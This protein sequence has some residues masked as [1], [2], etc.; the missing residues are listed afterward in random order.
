MT[1]SYVTATIPYVNAR[2]HIGHALEIVQVDVIASHKRK[3]GYD[4]RFV[5]G[6][7]DNA[8]KNVQAARK[9][10]RPV[11]EFVAGNADKFEALNAQLGVESTDFFRTSTDPRHIPGVDRLWRAALANDDLYT[12][13][14][15]GLYCIGCEEFV[16]NAERC[17]DHG[18]EPEVVAETNWFSDSRV[19]NINCWS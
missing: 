14:Y 12:R 11:G 3:R 2:P 13:E 19:M 6:S 8:L 17:P 18:V 10:N 1:K 16:D 7:D 9:A 15:E 4:V 5:C